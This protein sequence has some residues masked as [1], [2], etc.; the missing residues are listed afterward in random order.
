MNLFLFMFFL[1]LFVYLFFSLEFSAR[2]KQ[3]K[4]DDGFQGKLLFVDKGRQ[5]R[6]FYSKKYGIVAKPDYIFDENGEI[7]LV[8][9]KSRSNN[10]VYLS[11]IIQAKAASLAARSK[12]PVSKV[13]IITNGGRRE[14]SLPED[15]ENLFMD[16][17]PFY[18]YAKSANEGLVNVFAKD[19]R[20]CSSCGVKRSCVYF[21]GGSQ[22]QH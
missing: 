20:Q 3:E 21:R 15:D 7:V 1:I 17:E 12:Y 13:R 9:Y 18:S 8:E 14:I 2:K 4:R 6:A 22:R 16:I 19:P 11:D 5:S 10:R